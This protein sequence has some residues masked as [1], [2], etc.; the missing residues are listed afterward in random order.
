MFLKVWDG[1][2]KVG[3]ALK[4]FYLTNHVTGSRGWGKAAFGSQ[5]FRQW[6][7]ENALNRYTTRDIDKTAQGSF[8]L[9][10]QEASFQKLLSQ[11]QNKAHKFKLAK[12]NQDSIP[13]RF[14]SPS[15]SSYLPLTVD[16]L[17]NL[18]HPC[19]VALR[20]Y[21]TFNNSTYNYV[22][23]LNILDFIFFIH[24]YNKEII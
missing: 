16:L 19:Q 17:F 15:L 22:V 8:L 6:C 2:C 20:F 24:C 9:S 11:K 5:R 18:L 14:F 4:C 21:S 1:R 12:L 13:C 3:R 23:S 10:C 7:S